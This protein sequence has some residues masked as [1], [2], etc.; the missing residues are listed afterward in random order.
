M[1]F[2]LGKWTSTLHLRTSWKIL[3]GTCSSLLLQIIYSWWMT[4][5]RTAA[6]H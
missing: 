2:S 1:I 3:I 6:R 4:C 5:T